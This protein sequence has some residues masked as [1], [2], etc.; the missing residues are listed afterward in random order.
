MGRMIEQAAEG[1]A[2]GMA[3]AMLVAWLG[4]GEALLR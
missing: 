1:M 4:L 3:L 2:L